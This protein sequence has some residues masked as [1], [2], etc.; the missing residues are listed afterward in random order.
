VTEDGL[1]DLAT[2]ALLLLKLAG[3]STLGGL[4]EGAP[5]SELSSPV[6]LVAYWRLWSTRSTLRSYREAVQLTGWSE[7]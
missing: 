6:L 7:P 3:K 1:L 2:R 4:G 5:S